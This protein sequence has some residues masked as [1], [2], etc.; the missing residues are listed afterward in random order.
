M[1]SLLPASQRLGLWVAG[2]LFLAAAI[3]IPSEPL[4][5]LFL[6]NPGGQGEQATLGVFSLRASLA[7]VGILILALG[8]YPAATPGPVSRGVAARLRGRDGVLLAG[9][10]LV[11]AVARVYQ[12][13]QQLWLDEI[14]MHDRYMNTGFDKILTTFDFNNHL[15]YCILAKLSVLGLGDS[16]WVLRLPAALFGI[17]SVGALF[18][19]AAHTLGTREA[20]LS[21]ALLSLSYHH[22]WFSQNARGYTGALFFTL[23]SSYFLLRAFEDP[24]RRFWIAYAVCIA[25]GIY[26]TDL[27]VVVLA[28]HFVLYLVH[29]P[30][31]S[32]R[33]WSDRLS[34]L[35]FGFGVAGAITLL[36]SALLLPQKL[37]RFYLIDPLRKTLNLLSP[38]YDTEIPNAWWDPVWGLTEA[39]K[40]LEQGMGSLMILG[41]IVVFGFGCWKLARGNSDILALFFLPVVLLTAL[42]ASGLLVFPLFP[43]FY[44]FAAGFA[45][46]IA[47]SGV[48][49][50][51]DRIGRRLPLQDARFAGWAAGLA[52]IL[53]SATT[54]PAAYGPKQDYEGALRFVEEHRDPEDAVAVVSHTTMIPYLMYLDADWE[55]PTSAK[56]LRKLRES[57]PKTWLVYT[58]PM[59]VEAES[60]KIW[61]SILADSTE[62]ARFRG[63]LGDGDLV[64]R[65]FH[66]LGS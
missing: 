40:I 35:F 42:N 16:P 1:S 63:T 30:R 20:V 45:V 66:D 57:A 22:I 29:L 5:A 64:V 60:P 44:F 53:I 41:G 23:A 26:T 51:A 39:I 46:L 15:L 13:D 50:V 12:L 38:S 47:M 28:G 27:M 49:F 25:L 21:S 31:W 55:N 62:E 65:R 10:L 36:L 34:G 9:I 2:G 59:Q 61:A 19:F 18:V 7:F 58:L 52:V 43:R 56:D 54:V 48:L 32:S 37:A 11:A 3:G 6:A 33:L 24:R 14:M 4:V 17:A 8:Q